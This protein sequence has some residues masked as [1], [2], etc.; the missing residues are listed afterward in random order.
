MKLHQIHRISILITG[1]LVIISSCKEDALK[2]APPLDVPVINVILQDIP[3]LKE[4]VG[5]V[6]GMKDIPIRARVE[7]YLEGVHFDE[8]RPVKKGQLLYTIDAQPFL[9]E[10]AARESKVAEAKTLLVNAENELARYKPLAEINAVSKSDLDAAQSTRDAAVA[11]LDA[12]KANLN[13]AQINL[14][15]CTIKSPLD[16]LIGKTEAQVGEFVGRLPNPVILNVVS[17]IEHTKVQFFITE[18]EFLTL[19][20]ERIIESDDGQANTAQ[21]RKG[22]E[23]S[24]ILA[25]GTVY[26]EKGKY[27]FVNRNVDASTGS[28]LV[29]VDFPNPQGILRPGMFAKVRAKMKTMESALLVP[30][31]CVMELQGI[32]SVYVIDSGNVVKSRQVRATQKIEDLWLIEEGLNQSDKVVIDA[33]QKVTSG[34]EVNP[35]PAEFKNQTNQ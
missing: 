8:G 23:L 27:D 31:R 13:M 18:A 3:I 17:N 28:I 12:A 1:I 20:N 16:G 22:S 30:Q 34:L 19:I 15:Y 35:V 29:Q 24:L 25:D 6:Y 32:H 21:A 2:K 9:E 5:Q 11:S 14:G 33:L 7:G 4:F 10:V 26:K